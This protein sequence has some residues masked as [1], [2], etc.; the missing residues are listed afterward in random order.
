M[1]NTRN[2][3]DMMTADSRGT[4][5][6]RTCLGPTVV[7]RL[8]KLLLLEGLPIVLVPSDVYCLLLDSD[9]V[10]DRVTPAFVRSHFSVING[11]VVRHPSVNYDYN[12]NKNDKAG[13]TAE[14]RVEGSVGTMSREDCLSNA[15]FLLQY[16]CSDLS[17][18]VSQ[19]RIEG[20]Q[21]TDRDGLRG[22]NKPTFSSLHGL[23]VLPLEDGSLGVIEDPTGLPLYLCNEAER[24]ILSRAGKRIVAADSVLGNTVSS[25]LRHPEF[26]FHC[27][28][29]PLSP[30]DMLKVLRTFLPVDWFS[31][32]VSTITNRG[33][34]V[35]D[36]WLSWLWA[37]IIQEKAVGTFEGAFPL[38]PVLSPASMLSGS[39][40]VKISLDVPVLHMSFKDLPPDAADALSRLGVYVLNSSVL[41]GSA[42]SQDICRLISAASPKGLLHAICVVAKK[43]SFMR[44]ILSWPKELKRTFK[45]LILD[46]VINKMENDPI[47]DIEQDILLSIPVWE[48]HNYGKHDEYDVFSALNIPYIT[49]NDPSSSSSSFSSSTTNLMHQIP[50]KD[51]NSVFLGSQFLVLRSSL[52]RS[53]YG[54]LGI[55]EPSKG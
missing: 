46:H 32:S 43:E 26:P 44:T 52:D 41:G 39:Y 33:T 4:E 5:T 36:E 7:D 13:G 6:V 19:L 23:S 9:C 20:R 21:H 38:L 11:A 30:L 31:G 17:S 24:R 18:D 34:E 45:N 51:I 2:E 8:E 28:V 25:V 22:R 1:I 29:H 27:N 16:A 54:R 37:Y 15:L 49:S 14:G 48:K 47:N 53:L 12:E 50:P 55:E 35:T 40:L 3:N 10:R 42:Y